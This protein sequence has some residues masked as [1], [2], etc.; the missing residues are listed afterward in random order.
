LKNDTNGVYLFSTRLAKWVKKGY[1][2]MKAMRIVATTSSQFRNQTID[3]RIIIT[4]IMES[5]EFPYEM[6][7]EVVM[8]I[9]EAQFQSSDIYPSEAQ[10]WEIGVPLDNL[11]KC[12][13]K[14]D[15]ERAFLPQSILDYLAVNQSK[16]ETNHWRNFER[17][18]ADFFQRIGYNVQLG[19]G[20]KDGGIDIRA[21]DT[22]NNQNPKLIIQCKRHSKDNKVKIDVVKAFYTDVSFE[23]AEHGIIIT[24]SYIESGGKKVSKARNYPLRFIEN[25]QVKQIAQS[26]WRYK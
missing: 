22:S 16:I 21:F 24:T 6:A 3:P 18:C 7:V 5:G 20:S 2:P 25:E 13:V 4:K 1:D 17:F 15:S 8:A 9:A 23:N 14:A 11:F 10:E 26:M 12:E 19:P